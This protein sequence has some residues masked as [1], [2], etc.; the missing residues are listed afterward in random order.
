MTDKDDVVNEENFPALCKKYQQRVL[1]V[2]NGIVRNPA[3][4]EDVMQ[5][6]FLSAYQRLDT[7][8]GESLFST[9]LHAIA[10]NEARMALRKL[11]KKDALNASDSITPDDEAPHLATKLL[12]KEP[13]AVDSALRRERDDIVQAGIERLPKKYRK[14]IEAHYNEELNIN[15]CA[16]HFGISVPAMK[17]RLH[18]ARRHLSSYVQERLAGKNNHG[19][20]HNGVAPVSENHAS[21]AAKPQ[22]PV[23]ARANGRADIQVDVHK[24]NGNGSPK[25]HK[26][27]SAE[28]TRVETQ[29]SHQ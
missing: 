2:A 28:N 20:C 4:A 27:S 12:S 25:T 18:R 7:F 16:E 26:N 17:A 1:K 11:R 3:L 14:A 10:A 19:T 5:E 21:P 13:S 8:R 9:W 6:T 15:E 23:A 24:Q 29:L 22:E